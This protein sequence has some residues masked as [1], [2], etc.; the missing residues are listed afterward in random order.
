MTTALNV[1]VSGNSVQ[2]FSGH[3]VRI[4][5]ILCVLYLPLFS[6]RFRRLQKLSQA[7]TTMHISP[8]FTAVFSAILL[9]SSSNAQDGTTSTSMAIHHPVPRPPLL[10]LI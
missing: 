2:P 4:R 6:I 8:I 3:V 7:Q 1:Y 9:A 10:S 5:A